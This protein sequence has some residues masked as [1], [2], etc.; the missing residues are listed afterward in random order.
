LSDELREPLL[1]ALYRP[2]LVA[3][4]ANKQVV[5]NCLKLFAVNNGIA[6]NFRQL[7][8]TRLFAE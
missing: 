8:K 6:N 2:T 5:S 4:S 3:Y 1:T 7:L